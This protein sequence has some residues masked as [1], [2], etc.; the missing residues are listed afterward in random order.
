MATK[1]TF[2]QRTKFMEETDSKTKL[3]NAAEVLI[4]RH[5]ISATSVR[6]VTEAAGANVAMVK[7]HFGSKDGLVEAVMKR[8]LDP[9]NAQRLSLLGDAEKRF[10]DG[11]LPLEEVLDALFRPAVEKGLNGKK[12]GPLFLKLFGRIFAE[13]ASSM[14]I[15]R[16]QM[17]TMIKR[18]DAAFERALPGVEAS[19]MGWR[20]MA[21]FGVVQHSLLMLAMLDELP[22]PLRVPLK[23]MKGKPKPEQVLAQLIAFCAAGMRAK[24]S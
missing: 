10:P 12:D 19:D 8:H 1:R 7:Y 5:G 24:V 16:R 18:F 6:D 22:L 2:N 3:L 13:P 9:I 20:K 15:M 23:L 14:G 21:S 4:A 17:G 11:V